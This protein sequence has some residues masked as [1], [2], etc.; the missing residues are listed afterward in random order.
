ME[1]Q[2]IRWVPQLNSSR[3]LLPGADAADLLQALAQL[4]ACLPVGFRA[5]MTLGEGLFI[6]SS[7]SKANYPL[8]I[9]PL[10]CFP[11]LTRSYHP[12]MQN[13]D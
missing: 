4:C 8:K 11:H 12:G 2:K 7:F 5:I 3:S 13:V 1:A 6:S 9:S 10:F